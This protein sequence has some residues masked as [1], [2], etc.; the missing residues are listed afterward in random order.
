MVCG[1]PVAGDE[2]PYYSG[3]IRK[4]PFIRLPLVGLAVLRSPPALAAWP[5]P[6]DGG[7]AQI[8]ADPL[9]TCARDAEG[10]PWCYA[11]REAIVPFERVVAAIK[12]VNGYPAMFG[13]LDRV[14]RLDADSAWIHVDYPSPLSDRDYIAHFTQ[15]SGAE[16]KTSEPAG[17]VQG[18]H[19]RF[20]ATESTAA[21]D[22]GGDVRLV[23]AAGGYDAWD[24][25]GG[26]TRFRYTWET[27]I[28]GEVPAW[29]SDRARV[30]H[31]DEVVNGV[32][33]AA[34]G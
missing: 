15:V 31:G 25:G 6:P 17:S 13:H 21:P 30:L 18:F 29:M 23:R 34:G 19:V 32:I 26:R 28:G 11:E 5:A 24:L 3:P 4:L 22:P 14:K 16:I 9:I 27:E 2:M 8:Q 1:V 20:R 7:W 10:L 33:T 12:D